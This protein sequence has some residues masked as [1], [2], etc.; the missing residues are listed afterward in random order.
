MGIYSATTEVKLSTSY[1]HRIK[2]KFII[3]AALAVVA[4]ALPQY[5]SE[6]Q[7]PDAAPAYAQE[8]A[9]RDE[10]SGVDF[11]AN[12]E[13][14][15]YDTQGSYY[16]NLPD[17]R[18]QRVHYT[19][20]GDSGFVADVAYEGEAQYPDTPAYKPAPYARK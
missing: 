2:M 10:Y 16:V 13:R 20:N 14:N 12:E 6:P 17:G 19:V 18:L 9:V 5:P 7:Y 4:V 11:G 3:V 15:G 8:Y 1:S